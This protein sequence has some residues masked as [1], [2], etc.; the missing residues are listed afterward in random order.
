VEHDP[1]LELAA[2]I[3]KSKQGNIEALRT[4]LDAYIND[5]LKRNGHH[6]K[7]EPQPAAAPTPTRGETVMEKLVATDSNRP[8]VV[9]FNCAHARWGLDSTDGPRFVSDCIAGFAAAIDA[10]RKA[11]A[12][13]AAE[14][15]REKCAKEAAHYCYPVVAAAIRAFPVED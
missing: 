6:A 3:V 14:A 15:M 8:N 7:V 9:W 5:Y 2:A 11:A 13:E 4:A 12:T 1:G 10:E